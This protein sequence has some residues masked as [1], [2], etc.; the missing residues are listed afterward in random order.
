MKLWFGSEIIANYTLGEHRLS[1]S[2][3]L[4]LPPP[5]PAASQCRCLQQVIPDSP[6]FKQRVQGKTELSSSP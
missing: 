1:S 6:K 3:R 4:S 5:T 2:P